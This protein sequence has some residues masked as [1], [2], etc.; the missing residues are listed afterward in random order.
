M[1]ANLFQQTARFYDLVIS[2]GYVEA[3]I[4]FYKKIIQPQS[5]ILEV[6]CGTGRVTIELAKHGCDVA[7]IDLSEWMLEEFRKK[8]AL[9]SDLLRRVTIRQADMVSFEL[10]TC[11]DWIIFPYRVFQALTVDEKRGSCLRSVR[12]HMDQKSQVVITLFNPRKDIL[13]SWGEKGTINFDVELPNSTQRLRRIENQMPHDAEAQVIALE[14][15]YQ[16]YDSSG[17]VEEYLDRLEL[18]YLFPEQAQKLFCDSG[19]V[20]DEAYGGYDFEPLTSDVKKE[21][22]YI[23]KRA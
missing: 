9:H 4:P 5:R 22:I 20:I 16:V 2:R 17:V 18:G 10:G 13:A 11:F 1:H 19:F 23:L 15:I 21:Q 14:H 6:G 7:G 8:L 3:D 12:R